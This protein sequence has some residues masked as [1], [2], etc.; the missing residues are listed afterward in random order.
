MSNRARR[1]SLAL[2]LLLALG[3]VVGV[4]SAN[5]L[6]DDDDA[7]TT[8]RPTPAEAD[9]PLST[10]PTPESVQTLVFE[11]AFSECAS[12]DVSRLAG[13][14]KVAVETGERRQSR[15]TGVGAAIRRRRTRWPTAATAVSRA[16]AA[17]RPATRTEPAA[18]GRRCSQEAGTRRALGFERP[19]RRLHVDP[20]RRDKVSD[21]ESVRGGSGRPPRSSATERRNASARRAR[22]RVLSRTR[23]HRSPRSSHRRRSRSNTPARRD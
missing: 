20:P 6:A 9:P 19:Q 7:A 5:R 2:G 4:V 13:K 15:R 23:F 3:L 14:Y 17:A 18:P 22:R 21:P 1:I 16:S 8:E 11:R 10:E 12:Y